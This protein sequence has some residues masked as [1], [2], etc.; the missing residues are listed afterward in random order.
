MRVHHLNCATMCPPSARLVNGAGSLLSPGRLVCHCLLLETE[1]GLCLVDTGI[2]L[3][4]IASP[5]EYLG[6]TLPRIARFRLDPEETALR[7]V[8]RLGF[9]PADVRHLVLTHL[10]LDHAGG[11]SD[12]PSATVHVYAPEHAAAMERSTRRDRMRYFP[13]QWA[14]G[15][16]WAVYPTRGER[17]FGF[18]CVRGLEGLPPEILIVPVVGHTRGHAAI[19]VDTPQGW[20]LHAGDAYFFRGQMDPS[21]PRCPPGLSLFQRLN[22]TDAKLRLQNLEQL[23]A[24]ARDQTAQVRVF[25]AHDPVEYERLRAQPSPSGPRPTSR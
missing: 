5:R 8:E 4:A 15:P 11:L 13:A 10:D 21:R 7:Q 1:A 23:R 17:W 3:R 14:H 24:L 22:Q 12:F 16:R 6:P 25:C 18:D 2:G 20:L 19:A 9:R